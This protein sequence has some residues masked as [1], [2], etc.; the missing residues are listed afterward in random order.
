MRNEMDS[1]KSIP[2]VYKQSIKIY[3]SEHNPRTERKYFNS[4][5]I[6]FNPFPIFSPHKLTKF[7]QKTLKVDWIR[8]NITELW[9]NLIDDSY[10][11]EAPLWIQAL[12]RRRRRRRGKWRYLIEPPVH[13]FNGL[14]FHEYPWFSILLRK[15]PFIKRESAPWH[16]IFVDQNGHPPPLVLFDIVFTYLL[17]LLI[18]N[19]FIIII[20]FFWFRK[21]VIIKYK[22]I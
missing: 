20:I 21:N 16:H 15:M 11:E 3:T 19:E 5:I 9:S 22:N 7:K 18:N 8:E 14:M 2:K 1:T 13:I 17:F 4:R 12:K 10:T 6:I